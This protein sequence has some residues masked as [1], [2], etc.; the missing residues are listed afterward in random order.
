MKRVLVFSLG[1]IAVSSCDC[2]LEP[3]AQIPG[4]PHVDAPAPPDDP[5]ATGSIEG[6]VCTTDGTTWLAGAD[7]VI[8]PVNGDRVTGTT[9]ADGRFHVD[10]V[11]VGPQRVHITLGAVSVVKEATVVADQTTVIPDDVCGLNP[12]L[13]IAV[14]HGS[15]YDL[16]EGVLGDLGIDPSTIDV[17]QSDWANQL[18]TGGG[19]DAYDILMI[20]CRAEQSAFMSNPEMQQALR[21]FVANGGSVYVSDQSYDIVEVAFPSEVDFFGNDNARKDADQGDRVDV[22]ATVL[23]SSL[24]SR[25]GAPTVAL[26]FGLTTW[27]VMTNTAPDVTVY[28]KADVP[29]LNGDTIHDAPMTIGFTHGAGKVVYSSFHEEPGIGAGQEQILKLLMFEL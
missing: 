19:L 5:P 3:L 12:A 20:N 15:N 11:A 14:V 16:V 27:A 1:L 24:A 7:V 28:I 2:G 25:L 26:H 8:A 17:Y 6:R 10:G 18:L 9:D 22:D 21:D 29:L 13:R 23:D 4:K